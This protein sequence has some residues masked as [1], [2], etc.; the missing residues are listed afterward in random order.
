MTSFLGFLLFFK[1]FSFKELESYG[2][3]ST[4]SPE[5]SPKRRF[6]IRQRSGL[7]LGRPLRIPSTTTGHN[8]INNNRKKRD[9]KTPL[10]SKQSIV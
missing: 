2:D 6:E 9:D 8:D 5:S 1:F 10:A 3:S 7:G 4:T